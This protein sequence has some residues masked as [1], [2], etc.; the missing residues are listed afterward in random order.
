[1]CWNKHTWTHMGALTGRCVT[2]N[3]AGIAQRHKCAILVPSNGQE[4]C[5][6]LWMAM[7]KGSRV[8]VNTV[9][10]ESQN[11]TYAFLFCLWMGHIWIYAVQ[12]LQREKVIWKAAVIT[13][14][15]CFF[16]HC[17]IIEYLC[18]WYNYMKLYWKMCSYCGQ[19][20]WCRCWDSPGIL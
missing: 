3:A 1:M 5:G 18:L 4:R 8:N 7:N 17:L 11:G 14:K 16:W 6:L 9:W 20:R 12:R 19:R 2:T 13:S 15:M 10:Q